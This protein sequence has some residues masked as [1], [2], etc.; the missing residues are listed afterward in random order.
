MEQV[1]VEQHD[2]PRFEFEVDDSVGGA[3]GC[4]LCLGQESRAVARVDQAMAVA[5]GDNLDAAVG[6][7]GGVH[8]SPDSD[9]RIAVEM[10]PAIL[11]PWQEG[12]AVGGFVHKHG[13]EDG[14]RG[15]IAVGTAADIGKQG[16][17]KKVSENGIDLEVLDFSIVECCALAAEGLLPCVLVIAGCTIQLHQQVRVVDVG[18]TEHDGID[19]LL[20]LAEQIGV[21]CGELYVAELFKFLPLVFGEF[22]IHGMDWL[23][24]CM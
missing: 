12:A 8:G 7:G 13:P 4:G 3:D 20:E 22:C 11:M 6:F 2:F 23:L 15:V 10:C 19:T 18:F 5:A 1:I 21:D 9:L 17:V 14:D 24:V 16:L